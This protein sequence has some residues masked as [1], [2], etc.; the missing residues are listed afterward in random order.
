LSAALP[1]LH[2]SLIHASELL[3][4]PPGTAWSRLDYLWL[5]TN[6]LALALLC[7]TSRRT[8]CN[9]ISLRSFRLEPG[10]VAILPGLVLLSVMALRGAF[11]SGPRHYLALGLAQAGLMAWLAG[12]LHGASRARQLAVTTLVGILLLRA[13]VGQRQLPLELAD[14]IRPG[15][16][17]A[18]SWLMASGVEHAFGQYWVAFE[19]TLAARARRTTLTIACDHDPMGNLNRFPAWLNAALAAPSPRATIFDHDPR[20]PPWDI[21][22]W[23]IEHEQRALR[24]QARNPRILQRAR[25][26]RDFVVLLHD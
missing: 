17:E 21:N 10:W 25:F 13:L 6:A 4:A 15:R 8:L 14:R 1:Q 2:A 9:V 12:Y 11:L 16:E 20:F 3:I 19:W 7:W 5:V 26:G 22:P 18:M 23:A 24:F